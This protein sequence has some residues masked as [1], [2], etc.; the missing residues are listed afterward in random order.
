MQLNERVKIDGLVIV[1]EHVQFF[2]FSSIMSRIAKLIIDLI[3]QKRLLV[4]FISGL[5]INWL[6]IRQPYK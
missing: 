5:E 2:T 1:E 3:D 6:S 4:V